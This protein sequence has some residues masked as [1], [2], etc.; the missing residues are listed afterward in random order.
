MSMEFNYDDNNIFAK[1]LRGGIPCDKVYEDD[2]VLAFYDINPKADTHVLI[3]PKAKYVSMEDFSQNADKNEIDTL[4][5]AV[6]IV[7]EKIGVHKTGYKIHINV[8][9][10][11]GQ[12]VPHLHLHILAGEIKESV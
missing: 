6:H 4:I 8:G 5:R 1:I 2:D 9:E 10:G 12:E 7:A 3:I 11:A